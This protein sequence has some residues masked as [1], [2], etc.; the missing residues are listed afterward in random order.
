MYMYLLKQF[1]VRVYQPKKCLSRG[2]DS[3][4]H[5]VADIGTVA[6][7][8]ETNIDEEVTLH[9][10]TVVGVPELDLYK[11]CMKCKSS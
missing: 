8:V 1:V 2:E 5:T 7:C 6:H 3:E 11:T 10:V 4:C 9:N